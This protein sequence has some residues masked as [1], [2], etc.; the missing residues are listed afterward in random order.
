M[1][2]ARLIVDSPNDGAWNMSVDQALLETA[3]ETGLTTLRFYQWDEPTLSL[4]YFQNHQDRAL[5]LPSLNCPLVRRRTGGGAILHDR[6]LTYSLCV[7]STNRWSTKNGELYETIHQIII[8]YLKEHGIEAALYRDLE[9]TPAQKHE[10]QKPELDEP[11]AVSNRS[12]VDQ[13]EFMCFRRRSPGDVVLKGYKIVGSAQRR[14][15]SALLQHGTILLEK[16]QF[17][18]ELPGIGELAG[19]SLCVTKT[20]EKLTASA[21]IRLRT[22]LIIGKLCQFEIKAAKRVYTG[23][24]GNQEWTVRR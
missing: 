11:D 20:I 7:P 4:G 14:G 10:T 5:H 17:S 22:K 23:Q 1:D 2:R 13:N 18:P 15:K 21:E 19:I 16:S 8:E 9:T 12:S 6:E 3:N 24:F